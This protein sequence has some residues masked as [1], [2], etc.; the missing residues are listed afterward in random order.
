MPRS[1]TSLM[2][3]IL[4]S[5]TQVTGAGELTYIGEIASEFMQVQEGWFLWDWGESSVDYAHLGNIY[6]DKLAKIAPDGLCVTDKM[7]ANANF[8]GFIKSILPKAKSSMFPATLSTPALPVTGAASI[9]GTGTVTTSLTLQTI[10]SCI[11]R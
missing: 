9:K 7:P 4:A 5:H 2:E 8:L 1:G 3:Q 11:T 6:V 10:T